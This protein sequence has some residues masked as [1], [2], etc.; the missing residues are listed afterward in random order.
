[1]AFRFPLAAVLRVRESLE[2]KEQLVLEQCYNRLHELQAHLARLDE[3]KQNWRQR[4][5][6]QL[7]ESTIGVNV[8]VLVEERQCAERQRE[9]L[10]RLIAD[11]QEKLKQQMA[12]YR[13]VRQQR[14][15]VSELRSQGLEKYRRLELLQEQKSR[16]DLFLLRRLRR[17]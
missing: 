17:K 9:E 1:M 8:H 15:I 11:A 14:E 13:T 7:M 16:D 6:T 12:Q 10:L 5:E 2:R 3:Q 4:Y